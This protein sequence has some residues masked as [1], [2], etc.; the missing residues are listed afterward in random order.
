MKEVKIIQY[1]VGAMG[2]FMVKTALKRKAPRLVG[3]IDQGKK[4]GMD[5]G[6]IGLDGKLG[7]SI[8]GDPQALL[9]NTDADIILH[10]P[11]SFLDEVYPQIGMVIEAGMNVISICEESTYPWYQHPELANKIDRL[12]REKG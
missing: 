10:A 12:T 7:I 9:G 1:G 5:L 11:A 4:V 3:A 6:V 2:S 8:S